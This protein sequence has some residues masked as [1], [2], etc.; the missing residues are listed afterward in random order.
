MPVYA[1][2]AVPAFIQG[3]QPSSLPPSS[4]SSTPAATAAAAT[5]T[6][7]QEE[8]EEEEMEKVGAVEEEGHFRAS[9]LSGLADVCELLRWALQKYRTDV[10]DLAFGILTRE[11]EE[12]SSSSSS[13]SRRKERKEGGGEEEAEAPLV[14]AQRKARMLVRRAAAFL[15]ERLV[16]GLGSERL[17]SV[18]GL[19]TLQQIMEVLVRTE[20]Y[21]ERDE[22]TRV[23][24]RRGR[25]EVELALVQPVYDSLDPN[26]R[27]SALQAL[28]ERLERGREGGMGGMLG[29]M[30]R[31]VVEEEGREEGRGST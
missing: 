28:T 30:M 15:L 16:R 29:E 19:S 14:V 11:R 17:L 9:C 2:K 7:S 26:G 5:T 1:P 23:H 25:E 12:G 8:N 27:V 10:L 13:S 21:G 6:V 31:E 3:S 18:L 24:A 20:G 22:V 4:I